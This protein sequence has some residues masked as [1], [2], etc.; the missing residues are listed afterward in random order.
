MGILPRS[1]WRISIRAA[2]VALV[3]IGMGIAVIPDALVAGEGPRGTLFALLVLGLALNVGIATY[4]LDA[5]RNLKA[6]LAWFAIM[7][8]GLLGVFALLVWSAIRA[9]R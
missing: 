4:G 6:C 5:T 7:G 3:S 2:L 8:L 1:K 9:V